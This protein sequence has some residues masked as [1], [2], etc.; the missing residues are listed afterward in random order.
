[1]GAGA[2]AGGSPAPWLH[3]TLICPYAYYLTKYG[4]L[5]SVLYAALVTVKA[6]WLT[7][8]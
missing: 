4:A 6:V 3:K 2:G 8:L 1:M 5:Y 7:E